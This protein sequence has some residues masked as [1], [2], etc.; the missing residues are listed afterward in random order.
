MRIIKS[1]KKRWAGHVAGIGVMR[2][3]Y[4]IFVTE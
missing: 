3:V 4:K 2:I 1:R